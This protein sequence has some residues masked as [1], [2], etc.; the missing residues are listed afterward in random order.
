MKIL[1]LDDSYQGKNEYLGFGGFCIDESQIKTL[2]QEILNLKDS[3]YIPHDIELKWSPPPDHYLR[4]HF[5]GLRKNLY[6]DAI[7]ILYNHDVKI[8]C[9]VHDLKEC[10]GIKLHNWNFERTRLWATKQQVKFIAERFERPI[11]SNGTEYGLIIADHYSSIEGER[12]LI[13]EASD[14][15]QEGTNFRKF[16]KLCIP[17]LTSDPKNCSPI[18]LADIII[19]IVV[20][21]ISGN[22][23]GLDLFEDV[24]KLFLSDPHEEA[25]SFASLMSSAIFGFGLMLFPPGFRSKGN[26]LFKE[27]D[28]KYIFDTRG[29]RIREG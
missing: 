19:G 4:T 5:V 1:F 18:Q 26:D 15:F 23:F 17:P 7:H 28:K 12:S 9:A 2:I 11:L 13:K 8:I 29:L 22:R 16:E 20:A 6:R 24:A 14:T 27:L 3:Y 21:S 25:I 10:Y